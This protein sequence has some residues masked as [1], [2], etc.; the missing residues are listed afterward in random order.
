M[1][2]IKILA[3]ALAAVIGSHAANAATVL[4]LNPTQGA[5]SFVD[6]TSAGS[7]NLNPGGSYSGLAD[8]YIFGEGSDFLPTNSTTNYFGIAGRFAEA[9][10]LHYDS[11]P[12]RGLV[13]GSFDI[14][15]SPG[16]QLLGYV[17]NLAGLNSTDNL[18]GAFYPTDPK[19]V[20]G[21]EAA[22]DLLN[23]AELGGGL[24]RVSYSLDNVPGTVDQARFLVAGVP[25][26][27]QWATLL[28]GF[29]LMGAAI[30]RR[31]K[32]AFQPA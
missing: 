8:A 2:R 23:V 30:R 24:Y 17:T 6:L 22:H 10:L 29:F 9:Y 18:A 7:R 20:R 32:I 26:P 4:N 11:D 12:G 27:A 3:S 14:Q 16:Q 13:A 5:L 25:E 31:K 21:L 15:V 19:Q 28:A 1:R